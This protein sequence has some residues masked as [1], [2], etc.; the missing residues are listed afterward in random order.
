MRKLTWGVLALALVA[1]CA[2]ASAPVETQ[3][4]P[5]V[6][7]AAVNT[8]INQWLA[9]GDSITDDAFRFTS[10]AGWA[11]P[12]GGQPPEA[13]NAGFPG[14]TALNAVQMI[15]RVL[16]QYPDASHVGV[17]FGTNDCY[18]GLEVGTF[19]T[20]MRTVLQHL[21]TQ[22]R[23]AMLATIPYSPHPR[24]AGVEA[25]NQAIAE[26]RAEFGLPEGPDLYAWFQGHP[27]QIQPDQIHMTEEGNEAIRRLWAEAIAAAYR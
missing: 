21:R 17:A 5:P 22:G 16:G 20:A 26:L 12:F 19:K 4:T 15:D 2:Q 23:Q 14:A 9:F 10:S 18:G 24:M 13:A 8:P 11:A 6:E 3:A 7:V 25:Y 1:G 27:E